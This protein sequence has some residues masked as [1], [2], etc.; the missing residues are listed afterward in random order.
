MN[1]REQRKPIVVWWT[2]NRWLYARFQNVDRPVFR[3]VLQEFKRCVPNVR[4]W[5]PE[6]K[7]WRLPRTDMQHLALF[8][9]RVFGEDSLIPRD[10]LD[11]PIQTKLPLTWSQANARKCS[12]RSSHG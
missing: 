4:K 12:K 8:A 1:P 10:I 7:A 11:R 2:D 6:M 3:L 9:Q 5:C